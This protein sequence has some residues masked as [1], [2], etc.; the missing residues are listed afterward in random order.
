MELK[1]FIDLVNK[2]LP[3]LGGVT[4]QTKFNDLADWTSMHA[5]ILI[6][7]IDEAY[8]FDLTKEDLKKATTFHDIFNL[9]IAKK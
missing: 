6:S 7:S 9:I 5:L 8:Q 1:K 3:E 4:A 2:E